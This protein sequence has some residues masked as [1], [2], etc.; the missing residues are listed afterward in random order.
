M[1]KRH[2]LHISRR[3]IWHTQPSLRSINSISIRAHLPFQRF[4]HTPRN[5][6]R[7]VFPLFI[8]PS[9][10]I[11]KQI[12]RSTNYNLFAN[13]HSPNY[14]YRKTSYYSNP[15]RRPILLTSTTFYYTT[16]SIWCSTG[17]LQSTITTS[18]PLI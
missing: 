6:P 18:L 4:L 12:N 8:Q 17:A 14:I 1:A 9:S 7:V 13:L 15:Y 16:D 5:P 10:C 3:H 2:T 11:A